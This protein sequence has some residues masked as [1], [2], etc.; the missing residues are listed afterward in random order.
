MV[1]VYFI[2]R[3]ERRVRRFEWTDGRM[4]PQ[5]SEIHV[6][7]LTRCGVRGSL[8]QPLWASS[9]SRFSP[10]LSLFLRKLQ[11]GTR[12]NAPLRLPSDNQK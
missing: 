10:V 8:G 6:S 12:R 4:E 11:A 5:K 2:R 9:S 7:P 1:E 3:E